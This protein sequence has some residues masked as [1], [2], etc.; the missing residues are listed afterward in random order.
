MG[1]AWQRRASAPRP[2]ISR[3]RIRKNRNEDYRNLATDVTWFLGSWT[4]AA[5]CPPLSGLIWLSMFK[6]VSSAVSAIDAS[7]TLVYDIKDPQCNID[8]HNFLTK[9]K[10]AID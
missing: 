4:V 9:A 6:G 8:T 1:R 5:L 3:E 2:P 7:H 10:D